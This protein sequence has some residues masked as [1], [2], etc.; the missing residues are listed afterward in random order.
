MSGHMTVHTVTAVLLL[1]AANGCAR[2][3]KQRIAM[4]EEVNRNLTERLNFT[5]S[6]LDMATRDWEDLD[7]RLQDSLNDTLELRRNLA[8]QP[9]PEE[10]APGWTAV[11]GGAMIAIEGS[12][13][14]APGKVALRREARRALDAVV[15]AVQGEYIDK[16]I[17]VLG[18]TDGR[19][20]KKSGWIDNYQLSTERALAVVRYLQDRG[21][22]PKRLISGGCGEY[23]PRIENI[24]EANRAANR[25]VEILA[26]NP[27]PSSA[28][29]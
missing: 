24:S 2:Q 10:T 3:Q 18:H 23:R 14:F 20:I 25:R 9:T 12:V 16:D 28:Q 22:S 6:E 7:R 15:S 13:L 5:S 29:P 8:Q 17:L 27:F 11:P 4:L 21:V 19:P 26:I 1:V